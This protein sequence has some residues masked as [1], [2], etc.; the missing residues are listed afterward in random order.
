MVEAIILGILHGITEF[1]PVNR[2]LR[3]TMRANISVSDG[4]GYF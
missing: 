4:Y 1:P 2:A 3:Q